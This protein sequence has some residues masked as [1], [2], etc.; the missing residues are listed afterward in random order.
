MKSRKLFFVLF[1]IS[2]LSI[3]PAYIYVYFRETILA[4]YLIGASLFLLLT[5]I[6]SLYFTQSRIAGYLQKA[7][8]LFSA[9]YVLLEITTWL[10]LSFGAI[11]PDMRFF[12]RGLGATNNKLVNYSPISGYQPI[13][14]SVRFISISN[15]EAEIDHFTKANKMGWYSERDYSYQKKNKRIKRYMVLGDS[16]S[17]GDVVPT[18][19]IDLVQRFLINSGNDSIEL[20]NFSVDGSGIQNWY[21]I[22]FKDLVPKYEF[23]GLI[24]APSAEK[25]GVP[26]FDRKFIV[27]QSM[28]TRSYMSMVDITQQQPPKE[29]PLKNAIPIFTIYPSEELDR[30]KSQYVSTSGTSLKFRIYPPDLNFLA[31]LCGVSDGVYK[32]I[33]FSENFSAYNKPYEDY[34]R[35]SSDQYKME[36]FDSRYKYAYMLK[37]ILKYCRESNKKIIIAGIPDYEQS[38]G[39][40][41]GEKCIYRNELKFLA[42]SYGAG[43]F[44]GFGIFRG[45]NENFVKSCFYKNDLH[46]N[47]KGANLFATAFSQEKVF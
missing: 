47:E 41:R 34:Y 33:R 19:W 26:D 35:L 4:Y 20:Y 43:Y 1:N 28:D 3:I 9:T 39:F 6:L 38:L 45:Q 7:V 10:L 29:F 32:L 23:D 37:E 14:G 27:A 8:L 40:I 21:R 16:F 11:R 44:D 15:G 13:P 12:F 25:D 2:I 30:I 36:Y 18:T 5:Y 31:I 42:E 22:F 46:W 24:I 17:S